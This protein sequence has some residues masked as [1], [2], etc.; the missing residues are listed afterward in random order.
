M[1]RL[2]KVIAESGI[3]SRRKAEQLILD[4]KVKVNKE[5]IKELGTK[6]DFDDEILVE[7][8]P[9]KK[10]EKI[11]YI[12]NKP[13][14]VLSSVSDDK[15]R[16]CVVD[17]IDSKSRLYP[18][19]RLDY[20]SS[21]LLLITNDGKLTQNL[22]HPKYE[23]EKT[24]EVKIDEVLKDSEITKLQKG[25][26]VDNYVTAPS[27]IEV[28]KK[29]DKKMYLIVTIHEGKN[30]EIRKM[31][32]TVG[33]NVTRLHRIKEANIELGKL[34]SGEYRKL[35]PFELKKLKQFING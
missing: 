3:C 20:D 22:L 2:Q 26:K 15:N 6:V 21:G 16:T 10:E 4:G 12:I 34:K 29:D 28:V 25:V 27:K 8:K 1:E 13:K 35:K 31:F 32:N 30:R 18:V 19:G 9:I 17:L 14:G 5:V 24:Y 11:V 7:N 23:I 33:A